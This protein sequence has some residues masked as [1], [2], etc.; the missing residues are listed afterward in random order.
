M[1]ADKTHGDARA[2][3]DRII[4][5]GG[6]TGRDGIHGATFSSAE[7]TDTHAD[8][9]SHAVQIGNAIEEKRTLDA[10]LRARDHAGGCLFSAITDCGAGGF[11]SA[12][13]EMGEK[14]G[15]EV[16][17]ERAPLKYDG[18][19]Y[20]RS[21]SAR[22][23]SGWCSRCPRRT[24]RRSSAICDEEHV[25]LADLGVFGTPDG[26]EL[27]LH[28]I[29]GAEVG[30]LPMA[31]LHE[32]IP[33]PV[34]EARGRD[35]GTKGRGTEGGRHSRRGC[36]GGRGAP[37]SGGSCCGCSRI[38]TSRASTGSSGSTTTRCRATRW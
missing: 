1:P 10:I 18:L 13:G 31:F 35:E 25:E 30:R 15:A 20:T 26:R 33:T 24:S 2:P 8:E 38:R 22:A 6:R 16:Q 36:E 14:L 9:F 27:V 17:L 28:A 37:G 5:L 29:E 7:L 34:R 4:A 21:G 32:G 12:V 11:S 19:S 3:G 23:R